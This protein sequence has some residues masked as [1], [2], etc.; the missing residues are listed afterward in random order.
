M[1]Y[2]RKCAEELNDFKTVLE[3]I[4]VGDVVA[5]FE[6]KEIKHI[7]SP[8]SPVIAAALHLSHFN[9]AGVV[10]AGSLRDIRGILLGYDF[11]GL[12]WRSR[13]R[14]WHALYS[15][16]CEEIAHP[17]LT[18]DYDEK[19]GVL[20][21]RMA[22]SR[23]GFAIIRKPEFS[24]TLT[25]ISVLEIARFFNSHNLLDRLTGVTL[26]D[27]AKD[28]EAR[29]DTSSSVGELIEVMLRNNVR[30]VILLH[31]GPKV[32]TDRS[33][34]NYLMERERLT[35]LRDNPEE[36]FRKPVTELI[37]YSTAP[38]ILSSATQVSLVLAKMLETPSHTV[39]TPDLKRITTP[40]DIT[41][42]FYT[43][44]NP[45]KLDV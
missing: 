14:L 29:V 7:V 5:S 24:E 35:Q 30:R 21:E 13:R 34:V 41:V 4:T 37:P 22:E 39:I 31:E 26:G 9:I 36:L 11:I 28:I 23:L 27:V 2:S 12:L 18:V 1:V 42:G 16:S 33:V 19:L 15:T 8:S 45:V 38:A 25:T 20:L 44:T 17:V 32:I 10:I 40:W 6:E 3:R 43:R